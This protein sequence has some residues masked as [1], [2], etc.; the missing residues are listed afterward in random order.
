MPLA[1]PGLVNAF[2]VLQGYKNSIGIGYHVKFADP[3][4]F[5]EP[6]HH[7]RVHADRQPG[8]QRAR[9]CR[10]LPADYLGWRGSLS[11]NRSDFYDLFGPTKRSR[12]GYAAKI[13]YDDLLIYDEPRTADA[14]LRPGVLRQDRYAAQRAERH[15]DV[16]AA[17]SPRRSACI[18]P[19]CGARS[20]QSTTR[21]VSPGTW[22]S[23][24]TASRTRH[25]AQLRGEL[26]LWHSRS[27]FAHSSIWLRSAAGIG[28]GNRDNPVANFYFG[29]FGNN[30]VDSGNGQA[31]SRI[32]FDAGLRDR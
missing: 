25:P 11:W 32:L 30:Y 16:H 20:A 7:R 17:R 14:E 1:Q 18:T 23:K 31:L 15:D 5:A 2:P 6:R 21:K 3:L 29:G 12:K 24:A 28:T 9:A 26:R 27:P 4:H 13:G 10:K 8:G 22:S 19:T